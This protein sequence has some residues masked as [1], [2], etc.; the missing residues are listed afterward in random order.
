MSQE[1]L[2]N[3]LDQPQDV[4]AGPH[5]LKGLFDL[6]LGLGLKWVRGR[7]RRFVGMVG[8]KGWVIQYS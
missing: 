1:G 4:I 5:N 2:E 6:V 3:S 8:V 7:V